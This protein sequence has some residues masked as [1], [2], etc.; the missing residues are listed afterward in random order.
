MDL[1]KIIR[2][3]IK[4]S[5]IT[6][7]E[8]TK[9]GYITEDVNELISDGYIKPKEKSIYV[10]GQLDTIFNHGLLKMKKKDYAFANEIFEYC[11]RVNPNNYL[12]NF[13]LFDRSIK[14]DNKEDSFKYFNIVY[15]KL[16][17]ENNEKEANYYLL[18][19]S[20]LVEVSDRYKRILDDIL[21]DDILT[22]DNDENNIRRNLYFSEY[23][24]ANDLF[25]EKHTTQD[26]LS[27]EEILEADFISELMDKY[28]KFK[29]VLLNY[30]DKDNIPK[31]KD[32]LEEEMRKGL[33]SMNDQYLLKV[34]NDYLEIKEEK[35]LPNVLEYSDDLYQAINNKDYHLALTYM[36]DTDKKSPLY[37]MLVKLCDL[38]DS[39]DNKVL[40]EDTINKINSSVNEINNGKLVSIITDTKEELREAILKYLEDIPDTKSFVVNDKIVLRSSPKVVKSYKLNKLIKE[41]KTALYEEHD[42]EKAEEIYSKLLQ[43]GTP[44]DFIYG[45]YGLTI[46]NLNRSKEAIMYLSLAGEISQANGGNLDYSKIIDRVKHNKYNGKKKKEKKEK[47]EEKQVVVKTITPKPNFRIDNFDL[48]LD[49]LN[50]LIALVREG[51]FDLEEAMDKLKLDEESKNCV[52]ILYA[53]ECYYNSNYTEGD[54]YLSK[55]FVKLYENN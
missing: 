19:L 31:L 36:E 3:L 32:L 23:I 24:Q 41:A 10:V 5:Q 26:S 35:E 29:D 53:R 16:V 42:Y 7:L 28:R 45:E 6:T 48:K 18:L 2:I 37:V 34:V 15:E 40:D 12:V 11:Y 30:I 13:Q 4:N 50:D 38:I 1:D 22:T 47:K 9:I 46:L 52:R 17:K 25:K 55:V 43:V 39:M 49:Y 27:K 54:T 33:L 14:S 20:R 21:L 51:E 8:L 44:R